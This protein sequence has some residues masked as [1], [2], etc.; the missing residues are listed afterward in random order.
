MSERLTDEQAAE[1]VAR[2]N[3][4]TPGP[5]QWDVATKFHQANL[6]TT[7]SGRYYVMSFARWGMGGAAPVFQAYERYEGPVKE[8]GSL[9]LERVEHFAVQR[10]RH[11]EGWDQTIDHPDAIGLEHSWQDVD[12]LLTDRRALLAEI[13]DLRRVV[14]HY[15]SA[16]QIGGD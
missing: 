1:I 6:T 13:A 10:V 11:H 2:H 7:H 16:Q 5:Y 9:G 15:A 3:A 4:M 8:R 12:A 14:E